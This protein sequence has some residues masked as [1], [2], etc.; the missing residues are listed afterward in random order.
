MGEHDPRTRGWLLRARRFLPALVALR[1][2][3]P[4][5]TFM[6]GAP[7]SAFITSWL[8]HFAF[9]PPPWPPAP[10]AGRG[11][12]EP[13][14]RR[15]HR[16]FS[17]T[18]PPPQSNAS[19][20][21]RPCGAGG[22]GGGVKVK[23]A[24]HRRPRICDECRGSAPLVASQ[25]ASPRR[26]AANRRAS[27]DGRENRGPRPC[28]A[29]S[30]RRR[31]DG[32]EARREATREGGALH[33]NVPPSVAGC[34]RHP[35][36]AGRKRRA[37]KQAPLESRIVLAIQPKESRSLPMKD[38]RCG[39]TSSPSSLRSSSSSARWRA[40]Q[41]RRHLDGHLDAL[42]AATEPP[43]VRDALALDAEHRARLRALRDAQLA[44]AVERRHLDLAAEGRVRE[45]DGH[46][47]E[48]RRRPRGGRRDA[49]AP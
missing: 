36:R 22:R 35:A 10:Q 2:T 11:E 15:L 17:F 7:P 40:R 34:R 16:R 30:S 41:L 37:R 42:V 38:L 47:A 6:W 44:L 26:L 46:G 4:G 28:A 27:H 23:R 1:A 33:V 20:L 29:R 3:T 13:F 32:W 43:A 39:C 45:R 24:E 21:P 5:V 31:R 25:R 14:R 18:L 8:A 9:T 49:G 19:T 12:R 48:R